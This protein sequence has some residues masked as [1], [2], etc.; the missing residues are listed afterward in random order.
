[1][2]KLIIHIGYPKTGSS[3]L[4]LN[5]F[6]FLH[7]NGVIEYLNHLTTKKYGN[8]DYSIHKNYKKI[9]QGTIFK[10][11]EIIK[12]LEN[13]KTISNGTTVLSSE[14]LSHV[15]LNSPHCLS[16]HSPIENAEKL[17]NLFDPY[18][19]KIEILMFLRAQH[20][21]IPS[22]FV[23]VYKNIKR[24]NKKIKDLE[25]YINYLF[26]FDIDDE[27][28]NFNFHAMYRSYS[29]A[30]GKTHTHILFFEDLKH[31][32][33]II[34]DKLS[35]LLDCDIG[36]IKKLLKLSPKNVTV[37]NKNGNIVT[38]K[39]PLFSYISNTYALIEKY[40]FIGLN[41]LKKFIPKKILEFRTNIYKDLPPLTNKQ[42]EFIVKRFKTSNEK[43]FNEL[44]SLSK[45]RVNFLN[46]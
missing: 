10:K 22:Q 16:K 37:K 32:P 23:Q 11:D 30:F 42:K 4:Q 3:S 19:D 20:T 18:F 5:V 46:Y 36:V 7:K 8:G 12:E 13:L 39:F 45:E 1:M 43:L 35:S 15:G 26:S 6:S 38:D 29:N 33:G 31:N 2:K 27:L 44:S 21:L 17:K 25:S 34:A 41:K 9:L 14:S 28:L 24:R 40:D